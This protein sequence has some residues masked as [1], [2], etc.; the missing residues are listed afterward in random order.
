MCPPAA[1]GPN[2][3][4]DAGSYGPGLACYPA[5][6]EGQCP[7]G[8]RARRGLPLLHQLPHRHSLA[9]YYTLCCPHSDDERVIAPVKVPICDPLPQPVT[10]T[11]TLT[12]PV[13]IT[14]NYLGSPDNGVILSGYIGSWLMA[15]AYLAISCA[16]SALTRTQVVSF[17]LSLVIC[18]FLILCGFP[19]VI[20]LIESWAS[21]KLVEIV[22]AMSVITHFDGFQKGVLDSRDVIFFLSIIGF[23]LFCNSVIIRGHRAG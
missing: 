14:V 1:R 9:L 13:V 23:S 6:G 7:E 20:K 17:I 21:P 10:L 19:P 8:G 4:G 15:G 22:T 5:A 3:S 11:L 12:L 18:L 2:G 16:T